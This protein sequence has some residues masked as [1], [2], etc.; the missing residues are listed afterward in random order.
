M[1]NKKIKTEIEMMSIIDVDRILLKEYK[2]TKAT[3]RSYP[4]EYKERPAF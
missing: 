3:T 1:A 4:E 2:I